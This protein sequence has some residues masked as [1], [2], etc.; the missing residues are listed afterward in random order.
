MTNVNIA[1]LLSKIYFIIDNIVEKILFIEGGI[2]SARF[3]WKLWVHQMYSTTFLVDLVI[4][5]V[6]AVHIDITTY[7]FEY[8]SSFVIHEVVG[9]IQIV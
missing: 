3:Q 5:K 2:E 4:L 6:D 1:T 9:D 8:I 7:K